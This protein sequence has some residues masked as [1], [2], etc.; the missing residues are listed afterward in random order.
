MFAGGF[1]LEAA[2]AVCADLGL[3]EFDV[4]RLLTSLGDKS[5][6]GA[7][8]GAKDAVPVGWERALSAR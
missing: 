8:V 6:V 7:I 3:D 4:L 2:H 5:L 1:S